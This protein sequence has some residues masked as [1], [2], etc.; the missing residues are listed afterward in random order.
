MT[1]AADDEWTEDRL[2]ALV[3][4]ETDA[5]EFKSSPYVC[6]A[7]GTIRAD[8]LD[9]LSKQVSA[10]ANGGGGRLFLGLRDD[11]TID[12]GLPRDL[13]PNGTREW[14]EDVIPVLVDPPLKTFN[15]YEVRAH[16]MSSPIAA[17]RAVYV[18]HL[19]D[20]EDAPHQARDRRYYLRI[21]GKSRPM[22]H[23]HVLDV[24]QR[25]RDPEVTV[26]RVDP[27][28]EPEVLP[29]PRG[30][31]ALLRLRASLKNRGRAL[32]HHVGCEFSLPRFAVNSECRRRTLASEEG[33]LLQSPGE[34]TFFFYHPTPIFPAQEI[35]FGTVWLAI[36]D[37]N[38]H[39]YAQGR[40]VFRWKVYADEA[41][42]QE[43]QVDVSTYTSIQR[44][45][46]LIRANS[47]EAR[48]L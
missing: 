45:L 44:A 15:V 10:F 26:A 7:A 3:P 39:H 22:S 18:L 32:A 24:M 17:G 35:P 34:V 13:R 11:G 42:H 29:D 46:R 20:S 43:G 16:S 9:N 25:R 37:T 1:A 38:I 33:T 36:H 19:P 12:G 27:Y 31:C 41:R 21:A 8:F 23:R 30:P 40:V 14:L 2:A 47:D 4:Y 48:A 28:G 6:D 5:Q